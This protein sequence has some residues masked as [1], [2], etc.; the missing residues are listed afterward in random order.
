MQL[1]SGAARWVVWGGSGS[2]EPDGEVQQ[3]TRWKSAVLQP[4][5]NADMKQKARNLAAKRAAAEG[6][7]PARQTLM[8]VAASG[9]RKQLKRTAEDERPQA[10]RQRQRPPSSRRA[11]AAGGQ[12]KAPVTLACGGIHALDKSHEQVWFS[13][14]CKL[15]PC[16]CGT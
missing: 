10:R 11:N 6:L 7:A 14:R 5:F 12:P 8:P 16:M 1:G 15:N 4:A 9:S 3:L 13:T 2:Y